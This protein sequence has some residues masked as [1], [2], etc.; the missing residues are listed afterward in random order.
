V[1]AEDK[2]HVVLDA[3]ALI[4]LERGDALV[5]GYVLLCERG[6][7]TLSTSA[8][9]VAQVW[10]GGARQ[11]R[12]ARFLSS[13]LVTEEPLVPAASRRI[14]M[15]AAATA[16]VDVVDG[17]VAMIALERDAIVLTSDRAD[18]ERWGIAEDK[19]ADC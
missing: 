10:R 17:H 19:I 3:G 12:L 5:R 18:L 15:L 16:A 14:G 2:K 4:A 13:D 1:P 8:A 11:A 7:V 9:V 6:H